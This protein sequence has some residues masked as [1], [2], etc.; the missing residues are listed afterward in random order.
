MTKE[1]YGRDCKVCLKPFT[2]FRWCPGPRMR[3][4]TT[5]ICSTCARLKNI[6]QSCMLDL[7]FGLPVQVRDTVLGVQQKVPKNEANREYFLAAN[8]ERLARG[9][10]SL[11]DY[12]AALGMDAA[13]RATLAQ[14]APKRAR[15]ERNLAAPCSFYA[16]G[17]CTRG[18][19]C[20][21]RH[22][23]VAERYP[24]LQSYRDRYYGENDPAAQRIL[25]EHPHLAAPSVKSAL[26]QKS[27]IIRGIRDN[28]TVAA[29]QA[30]CASFG[31]LLACI[32]MA[33]DVAAEVTFR[34]RRD[35]DAFAAKSLGDVDIEGISVHVIRASAGKGASP[36][37]R[38]SR[39]PDGGAG[40]GEEEEDDVQE[41]KDDVQEEKD[42]VQEGDN[43]DR[44]G[45]NELE[46]SGEQ[47]VKKGR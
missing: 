37:S 40:M 21:Y 43:E 36:S 10:G 9:D 42:D 28:L 18:D 2:I 31:P 38:Q 22:V 39:H 25:E 3:F 27:F 19:T 20:P 46:D 14:L 29:V 44:Q 41:E 17:R 6:C 1:K 8:A 16:K 4:R 32:A 7:Q 45:D 24:S 13:A 23:L 12:E 33:D 30:Y 35:A 26:S 5:E 15:S 34:A 47:D 11:L